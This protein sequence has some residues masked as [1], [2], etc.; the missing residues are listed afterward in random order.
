VTDRSRLSSIW[1]FP[2]V[3]IVLSFAASRLFP[4]QP[5]PPHLRQ[6]SLETTGRNLLRN[7]S[8]ARGLEGWVAYHNS[9]PMS[10]K[11]RRDGVEIHLA[12]ATSSV[13]EVYQVLSDPP[14]GELVA[15]GSIRVSG[16]PLPGDTTAVVMVVERS[17]QPESKFTVSAANGVGTFPFAFTYVPSGSAR[18]FVLGVIAGHL[19]NNK[20]IIGFENLKIAKAKN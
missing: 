17:N 18:Q 16:A 19:S 9:L 4:S 1:F 12:G 11:T 14:D 8:F 10:V 3:V 7:P 6:V 20:T 2:M 13:Q 5:P 15:T